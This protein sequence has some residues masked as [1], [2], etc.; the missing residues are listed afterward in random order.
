MSN[1]M[2]IHTVGNE[3]FCGDKQTDKEKKKTN[4]IVACRNLAKAFK[5]YPGIWLEGKRKDTKVTVMRD[6]L[7]SSY[8]RN[9]GPRNKAQKF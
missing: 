4:L 1:L 8:I 6:D 5:Y 7:R 3:L 9:S 2:K